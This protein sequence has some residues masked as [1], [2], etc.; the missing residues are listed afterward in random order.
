MCNINFFKR[1]VLEVAV[2]ENTVRKFFECLKP[3]LKK[4]FSKIFTELYFAPTTLYPCEENIL[5]FKWFENN[6]LKANPRKSYIL[7]SNNKIE[8]VTI[9]DV[10]LT[11]SLEEKSLGITLDCDLYLKNT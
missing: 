6:H 9:H 1:K 7:L 10:V 2:A 4:R 3:F 11:S 5:A 8:K